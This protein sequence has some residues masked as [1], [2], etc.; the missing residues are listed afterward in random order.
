MLDMDKVSRVFRRERRSAGCFLGDLKRYAPIVASN[1]VTDEALF[2]KVQFY[3]NYLNL[4]GQHLY[5][6]LLRT[7]GREPSREGNRVINQ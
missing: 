2:L 5:D 3:T 6:L 4:G 1:V 7:C